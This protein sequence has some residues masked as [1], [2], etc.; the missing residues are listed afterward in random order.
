LSS[1]GIVET[2][3]YTFAHHPDELVLDSGQR[4]GPITLAYETYGGLNE[5]KSNAIL[6]FHALS[7][8]AHAAG[9]HDPKDE[10]A[11]WWDSMIG[12]GKAFDTNRYFVICANTIG[13]CKGSTGP[14]SIN[15]RTGRPYGLDFPVFTIR[16]IVRSQRA[17][18][19]HLGIDRLLAVAGGSMAG[20]ETLEWAITYPNI[21]KLSIPI[22]TASA[23]SAQNI[24]FN[25]MGRRAIMADP[26]WRKGNYYGKE[27]PLDGLAVARM[28]G[29]VTY[30]SDATLTSK[31]GRKLENGDGYGFS[32]DPEFQVES[33][34]KNKGEAFTRRFDANSYLYITRAIDYFDLSKEY[35]TLDN[36]IGRA[37]SR[38]LLLS[39]T[40][41]WLYP[42]CKSEE[43]LSA[44]HRCEKQGVHKTVDSTYGHDAFLVED[45]KITRTIARALE[46]A[47]GSV[48]SN[49]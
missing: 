43:I 47:Y 25:E 8:D 30:L 49:G 33:Y 7:G 48:S 44:L 40:S 37:R 46:E 32:L 42:P 41:D 2:K 3:Y 1:V 4:L 19:D 29:H 35:G 11:G 15:P 24:A 28:I 18:I 14:S 23:Q 27:P 34:L 13:G 45:A 36:A 17:L 5:E 10:K 21:V 20:M 22:A 38:F 16:D 12:P 26:R 31:F 9:K 39:F 6:I